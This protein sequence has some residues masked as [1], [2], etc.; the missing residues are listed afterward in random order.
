DSLRDVK[1]GGFERRRILVLSP[2]DPYPV[3]GGDR[4]RIHRLARELSK[5]HELTLLTFCRTARER[6]A[7]LPNDGD[8]TRVHRIVLPPWRSALSSL[9]ALPPQPPLQVAYVRRKA[10][11]ESVDYLPPD[12]DVVLALLVRMAAYAQSLP[13]LRMLEMTDA[14]SMNMQRVA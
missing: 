8:F 6:S 14:I 11:R 10:F 3:I 7:P 13:A 2:R 12:H 1:S 5:H 4:V 9:R